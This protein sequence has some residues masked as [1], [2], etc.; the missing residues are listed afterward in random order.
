MAAAAPAKAAATPSAAPVLRLF[1]LVMIFSRALRGP[2]FRSS[3]L[4]VT[5]IILVA[6]A[7]YFGPRRVARAGDPAI[8]SC[9]AAFTAL[10]ELRPLR[11]SA[12]ASPH[13]RRKPWT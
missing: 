6:E 4:G 5:G 13:Y 7:V 3:H 1:R 8:R 9:G 12:D 10:V 11:L 2:V